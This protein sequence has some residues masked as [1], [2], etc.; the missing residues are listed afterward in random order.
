[1]NRESTYCLDEQTKPEI[2]SYIYFN[3]QIPQTKRSSNNISL[4]IKLLHQNHSSLCSLS[5]SCPLIWYNMKTLKT[6][7]ERLYINEFYTGL[8]SILTWTTKTFCNEGW[9]DEGRRSFD[10]ILANPLFPVPCEYGYFHHQFFQ[11][12]ISSVQSNPILEVD[13]ITAITLWWTKSATKWNCSSFNLHF[14]LVV[15]IVGLVCVDLEI[16]VWHRTLR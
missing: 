5:S 14:Q 15:I 8:D 16:R 6:N 3:R 11:F 2:H 13:H 9:M 10:G 7:T 1:M 12:H 4:V